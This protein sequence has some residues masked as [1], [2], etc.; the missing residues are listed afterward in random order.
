MQGSRSLRSDLNRGCFQDGVQ[1]SRLLML[2][3]NAG[4]LCYPS[5]ITAPPPSRRDG[6]FVGRVPATRLADRTAPPG[7]GAVVI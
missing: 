6:A 4:K 5:I 7:S 1:K 2:M 3:S